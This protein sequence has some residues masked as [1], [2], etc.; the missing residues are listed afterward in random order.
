MHHSNEC[1]LFIPVCNIVFVFAIM[2]MLFF[3]KLVGVKF[4][5]SLVPHPSIIFLIQTFFTDFA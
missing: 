1:S 2:V 4:M 5:I 3:Y